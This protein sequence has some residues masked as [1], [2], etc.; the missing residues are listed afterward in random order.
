M[1]D[2]DLVRPLFALSA[3]GLLDAE[4]E[5]R[6]RE[7]TAGCEACS[8]E[9]EAFAQLAAGLRFM[10]STPPPPDLLARTQARVAAEADRREGALLATAAAVLACMLMLSLAYVLRAGV[11]VWVAWSFIPS[12]LG[13]AAALMLASRRRV[14][15]SAQ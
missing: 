8:A 5:R 9:L 7:H 1:T 2:H 10:P 13:G 14:E 15:R 4:G 6:L 3:A 12:V 11:W